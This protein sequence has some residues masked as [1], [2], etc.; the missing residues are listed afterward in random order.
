M[1]SKYVDERLRELGLS[2]TMG[3]IPKSKYPPG[4]MHKMCTRC[5]VLKALDNFSEMKTGALGRQSRCKEC[6]C[7][8]GKEYTRKHR[9]AKSTRPRPDRCDC[10]H[11]PHT[12]RRAMHWDHDHATGSFRGWL[13]AGCNTAIGQADDSINRLEQ[14]ISYLERGGGP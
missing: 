12:A 13:C 8:I 3:L 9:E 14:M 11:T 7:A 1:S 6:I 2:V 5:R 10:C 4:S